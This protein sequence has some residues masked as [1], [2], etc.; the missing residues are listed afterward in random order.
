MGIFAF[1]L[2]LWVTN[3]IPNYVT[4]LLV[5]VLLPVTGAWTEREALGYL[6]MMLY[7]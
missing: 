2:I 3:G 6:A 4:S 1:A 5:L 7:G